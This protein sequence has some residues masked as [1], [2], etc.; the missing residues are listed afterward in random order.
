MRKKNKKQKTKQKTGWLNW[1][2]F[3]NT[4]TSKVLS[5]V[6]IS[7]FHVLR[8]CFRRHV[9]IPLWCAWLSGWLATIS[10]SP[11]GHDIDRKRQ[12]GSCGQVRQEPQL[13]IMKDFRYRYMDT[14][15]PTH[16]CTNTRMYQH[17]YVPTHVCTNTHTHQHTYV[18]T[19]IRTN[20]HTYQHTYVPTL[21][22]TNTHTYQ[23]T[24][25]PTHIRTNT[26][27]YQHTYVPTHLRT[28]T[29]TYQHWYVPPLVRTHA[30]SR[31]H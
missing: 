25:V 24:Y 16:V 13:V 12:T 19:H 7:G 8:L 21:L 20:T 4:E 18:P 11:S 3:H 14:Y 23:H 31:Q 5:K 2:P 1:N 6:I 30:S 15:I 29:C 28:N 22:R 17:T 26:L 10:G 27:T 9:N